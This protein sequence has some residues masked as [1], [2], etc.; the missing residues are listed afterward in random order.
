MAGFLGG[1]RQ[2]LTPPVVRPDTR[3]VVFSDD[4]G[5]DIDRVFWGQDK[6]ADEGDARRLYQPRL[7]AAAAAEAEQAALVERHRLVI[8][9]QMATLE[10]NRA[11]LAAQ[12][13]QRVA[14]GLE[15]ARQQRLLADARS[16][17]TGEIGRLKPSIGGRSIF[18]RV[19]NAFGRGGDL[20]M[21]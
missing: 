18:S 5:F 17:G 7:D 6:W 3:R 19:D 12:T 20:L 16:R 15:L 1:K 11:A 9:E 8:D 14:A 10:G 21:A 4:P 2:V 13:E